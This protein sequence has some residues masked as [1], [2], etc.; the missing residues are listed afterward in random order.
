MMSL[1]HRVFRFALNNMKL[2]LTHL[3][4]SF[5]MELDKGA[6]NWHVGQ[7]VFNSWIQPD[8]PVY[9]SERLN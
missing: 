2:L 4:W 9:L 6:K 5:D 8:L 3:I 7:K 1:I